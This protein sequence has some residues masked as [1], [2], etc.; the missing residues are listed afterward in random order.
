MTNE[1]AEDYLSQWASTM[2]CA[3]YVT[4][5]I[6]IF[7]INAVTVIAFARNHRLRK[8]TTYLIINLTVAD[9]LVG[10]VTKPMDLYYPQ[11]DPGFSWQ[12]FVI[13]NLYNMFPVSS[14]I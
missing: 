7:T 10:V 12:H 8:R 1:T 3:V 11:Y 9:L 2:W 14:L 6:M 5:C 4:E 13:F